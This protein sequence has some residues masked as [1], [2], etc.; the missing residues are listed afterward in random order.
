MN[1]KVKLNTIEI[2]KIKKYARDFYGIHT[3]IDF[4]SIDTIINNN[5]YETSIKFNVN[6]R[7]V[8]IDFIHKEPYKI[9]ADKNK[10][11][12]VQKVYSLLIPEKLEAAKMFSKDIEISEFF[13]KQYYK[14]IES[15]NN[16]HKLNPKRLKNRD[17][18]CDLTLEEK[19]DGNYEY[20][21]DVEDSEYTLSNNM[22][23]KNTFKKTMKIDNFNNLIEESVHCSSDN[24]DTVIFSYNRIFNSLKESDSVHEFNFYDKYTFDLNKNKKSITLNYDKNSIS[25]INYDK[26]DNVVSF[27][28]N[29]PEYR[30]SYYL[31]F[32]NFTN[33]ISD[34]VKY[35]YEYYGEDYFDT[36]MSIQTDL[37]FSSE[38]N[39]I[40]TLT[41]DLDLKSLQ[42]N[43]NYISY[44]LSKLNSEE[45]FY[46]VDISK[47]ESLD[48]FL[49][50]REVKEKDYFVKQNLYKELCKSFILSDNKNLL[51]KNR[52]NND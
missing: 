16:C 45:L 11:I 3:N 28:Y 2:N 29:G 5:K 46:K 18:Y 49:N 34:K 41:Y 30:H 8:S 22:N 1:D 27:L 25:L 13:G 51:I 32:D 37:F 26:K 48:E 4:L 24:F 15:Y 44:M 12:S 23:K 17:I 52:K 19:S 31:S 47:I 38:G 9:E 40:L 14:T 36:E 20:K 21:L 39:D 50:F 33:A 6:N 43:S 7:L 10:Y 35:S 42:L